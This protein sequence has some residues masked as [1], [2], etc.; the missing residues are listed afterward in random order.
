MQSCEFTFFISSLACCIADG[1]S[2]DEI[3]FIAS[4]VVQ[5]GDTL[6]AIGAREAFCKKTPGA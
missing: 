3:N 4:V 6:V 2:A 5:L 1:K